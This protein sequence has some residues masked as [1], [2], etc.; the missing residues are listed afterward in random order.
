MKFKRIVSIVLCAA[1]VMSLFC[2]PTQAASYKPAYNTDTPVVIVHGMSQNDTYVL[3]ED[4]SWMEDG[5][6]GYINGWPLEIDVMALVKEALPEMLMSILFRRDMGLTEAMKKGT[7]EALYAI[8]KDN[9][10][11]Y[12]TPVEVPC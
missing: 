8:H 3:N 9:Q 4:G 5:N 11:N 2:I 6:G 1:M 10:G 12:L 7:Y